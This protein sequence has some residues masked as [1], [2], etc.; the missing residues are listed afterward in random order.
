MKIIFL[1]EKLIKIFFILVISL[2]EI[3]LSNIN[4]NKENNQTK[5]SDDENNNFKHESKYKL[6]NPLIIQEK[7]YF[8]KIICANK[9]DENLITKNKKIFI[10]FSIILFFSILP[11]LNNLDF[12]S[13]FPTN[14]RFLEKNY[15]N[16]I[17][18]NILFNQEKNKEINN[19]F[20]TNYSTL[21]F[22]DCTINLNFNNGS[23]GNIKN[24]LNKLCIF[25]NNNLTLSR[26]LTKKLD[27]LEILEF[28]LDKKS[29]NFSCFKLG[30]NNK[31]SNFIFCNIRKFKFKEHYFKLFHKK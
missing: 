28:F 2:K 25:K 10:D 16:K 23:E 24:K 20:T 26:K 15:F 4:K 14:E 12:L 29:I 30:L 1:V 18:K 17:E 13:N 7:K 11:N 19:N 31:I 5:S 8:Q 22:Q 6:G 3:Y 21:N 27:N 9:Q